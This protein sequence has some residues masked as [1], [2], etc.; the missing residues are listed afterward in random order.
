MFEVQGT[1]LTRVPVD[2]DPANTLVRTLGI[3]GEKKIKFEQQLNMSTDSH[4]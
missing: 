1:N 2:A 4:R 3:E